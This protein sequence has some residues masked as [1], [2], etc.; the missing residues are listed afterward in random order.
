MQE[1]IV[2]QQPSSGTPAHQHLLLLFHGVG[3]S[4]DDL[5]PLGSALTSLLP[6]TWIVS[7]RSPERSE[8]GAG[9]QWFSVRGVTEAN[10]PER[11]AQ[12]MP[13]FVSTVR[14]WQQKTGTAA[15]AT[16]LAGFSQGAIMALESTQHPGQIAGRVVAM[17][18]RFAS[19]PRVAHPGLTLHLLHGDQDRVMPATLARDAAAQWRSLGGVATLDVFTGLGHGIDSRVVRR[20]AE[21]MGA[22]SP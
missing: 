8:A 3:S 21:Y 5:A 17:A 10:R 1:A 4:A 22:A 12:A 9:W 2:I 18:G 14:E 20:L 7:V 13:G 6:H 15:H 11:V 16:T 19:P